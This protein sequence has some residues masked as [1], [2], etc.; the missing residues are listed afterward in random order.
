MLPSI[1][2]VNQSSFIFRKL[3]SNNIIVVYKTLHSIK[4]RKK[5][6]VGNMTLK[7]DILKVYDR[8]KL[9]FIR[10][11]IEKLDFGQRWISLVMQCIKFNEL[12]NACEWKAMGDFLFS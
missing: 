5:V 2:V 8:V 11:I 3:V 6:R 10:K 12:F 9:L 4:T 1:I 7:L